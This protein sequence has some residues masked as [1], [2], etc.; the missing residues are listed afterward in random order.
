MIYIFMGEREEK[1][2]LQILAFVI[3][4]KGQ[5]PGVALLNYLP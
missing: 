2:T 4:F 5:I 3:V 1:E